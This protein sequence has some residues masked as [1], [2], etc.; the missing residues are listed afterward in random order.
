MSEYWFYWRKTLG[1]IH[2]RRP[3]KLC[4]FQDPQPPL[5][6][7]VQNS[8]PPTLDLGRPISNESSLQMISNQLKENII[9]GWLYMLSC[10]S[11]RSAFVFSINSLIL[12]GLPLISFHL[13]EP[14][15]S[16]FWWLYTSVCSCPKISRNVFNL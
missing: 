7:H 5:F 4:N 9:Q 15:L 14:S 1:T 6:I 2:I 8:L 11:F 13:A 10:Q 12:P 16:A 3:W